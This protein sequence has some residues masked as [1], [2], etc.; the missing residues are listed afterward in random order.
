MTRRRNGYRTGSRVTSK[1]VLLEA[2]MLER[3]GSLHPEYRPTEREAAADRRNRDDSTA[4][5]ALRLITDNA[6]G[7]EDD[8]IDPTGTEQ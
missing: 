5:S 7:L 6:S 2:L 8:A 1:A 3:Y 4:P